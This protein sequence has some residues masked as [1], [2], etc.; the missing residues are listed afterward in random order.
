MLSFD[1]FKQKLTSLTLCSGW[2]HVYVD[3]SGCF[4]I[5]GYG[6]LGTTIFKLLTK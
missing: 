1:D 6:G 4:W 2:L 5:Q 3:R